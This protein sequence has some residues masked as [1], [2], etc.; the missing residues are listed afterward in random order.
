MQCTRHVTC[1]PSSITGHVTRHVT[2]SVTCARYAQCTRHVTCHPSSITGHAT[3]HVTS[4]VTI[5]AMCPRYVQSTRHVTGHVHQLPATLPATL[6][7]MVA[8][9]QGILASQAASKCAELGEI[10]ELSRV[11]SAKCARLTV[12]GDCW[13]VMRN[14][15]GS[16]TLVFIDSIVHIVNVTSSRSHMA[17]ENF[18]V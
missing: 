18:D 4:H 12:A 7:D 10:L 1:H 16:D 14:S 11:C 6:F 5:S 13:A 3:C 9:P 17:L 15:D 8:R 2:T